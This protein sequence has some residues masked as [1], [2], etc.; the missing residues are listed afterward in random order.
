MVYMMYVAHIFWGSIS[1]LSPKCAPYPYSLPEAGGRAPG[2]VRLAWGAVGI[3]SLS[4]VKCLCSICCRPRPTGRRPG[5][6]P[7]DMY[8]WKLSSQEPCSATCTTGT[9]LGRGN[10]GTFSIH[11]LV[12]PL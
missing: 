12:W 8:R 6:S 7:A 1:G 5:V 11:P 3:N 9:I 10:E 2:S 4:Q